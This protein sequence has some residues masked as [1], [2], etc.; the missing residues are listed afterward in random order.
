[1]RNRALLTAVLIATP[2]AAQWVHVPTSG[3]P[4]TKD[5]KPNLSASA[6][7]TREGKPDLSG[8]W[9]AATGKYLANIAADGIEIPIQPW[10]AAV[11]KE[12]Q[13]Q[14]GK[15]HP[16][17]RC[18]SHG[19]PDYEALAIPFKLIQTTGEIAVLYEAFN[20]YR[21][22]FTDGRSFPDER[23]PP[24]LG[25]SIGKWEGDTL[26]ADTIGFNDETWLDDGGHP[27]TDALHITERFRR[28]DFGHMEIAVTIDDPKAY[29]KPWGITIPYNVLPDTE[30]IEA[31][32]AHEKDMPHMVGK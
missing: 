32:C 17:E 14:N 11:Y 27:H 21:Q 9:V 15:G 1:M 25:Y 13:E 23:E 22:I 30:L 4:R 24:W 28:K 2:I 18:I 12:H 3:I 6:P 5:G 19:L 26:V 7:R 31:I 16:S 10:A 29:T 8:I 20:H